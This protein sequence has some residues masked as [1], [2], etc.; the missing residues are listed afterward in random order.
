[1]TNEPIDSLDLDP[2]DLKGD[3]VNCTRGI[4]TFF[5]WPYG[6]GDKEEIEPEASFTRELVCDVNESNHY[7]LRNGWE[8]DYLSNEILWEFEAD[9]FGK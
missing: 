4:I 6:L 2:I 9:E 1:M 7:E 8:S 3:M 5:V